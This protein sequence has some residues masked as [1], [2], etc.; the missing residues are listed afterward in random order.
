M[1]TV[2]DHNHHNNTEQ[3]F[4]KLFHML[5]K[6]IFN[7]ENAIL[8]SLPEMISNATTQELQEAFEDHELVTRKQVVRLER[9]FK[10]L[11]IDY[12][13]EKC[14]V[15]DTYAKMVQKI[16]KETK[17]K[18]MA[19][20][21]GLIVVAQQIEHYEIATYGGLLQFALALGDQKTAS[22]LEISL[23]EEE[24]TDFDLTEIAERDINLDS[25][26]DDLGEQDMDDKKQNQS[27]SEFPNQIKSNQGSSKNN[28]KNVHSDSQD[29]ESLTKENAN[30]GSNSLSKNKSK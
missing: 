19:R 8:K 27:V 23:Q 18:S 11:K 30:E 16:I 13:A 6:G 20:D 22:L 24:Q 5:L 7:T 28:K 21:A 15:M 12:K 17:D 25:M 3:D 1:K 4:E 2:K 9:I 29:E 10:T 14:E 26:Q